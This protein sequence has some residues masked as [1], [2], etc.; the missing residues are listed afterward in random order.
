MLYWQDVVGDIAT[1]EYYASSTIYDNMLYLGV[2]TI[3]STNNSSFTL[4]KF[5]LIDGGMV[6]EKIGTANK[7]VEIV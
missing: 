3:S 4:K 6:G 2:N 1:N 7:G 5:S